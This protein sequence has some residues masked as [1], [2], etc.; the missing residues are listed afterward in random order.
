MS[1]Y[2]ER[3][4]KIFL[5]FIGAGFGTIEI[6]KIRKVQINENAVRVWT[7]TKDVPII[8][9][10]SLYETKHVKKNKFISTTI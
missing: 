8:D 10:E 6:G 2:I 4:K 9:L 3:K 1:K 5:N 7:K